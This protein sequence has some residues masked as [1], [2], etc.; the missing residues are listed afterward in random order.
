MY[1]LIFT[2]QVDVVYRWWLWNKQQLRSM[3]KLGL[4]AECHQSCLQ[5]N[6]YNQFSLS[7]IKVVFY[8]YTTH[9]L[10]LFKNWNL[11]KNASGPTLYDDAN[12]QSQLQGTSHTTSVLAK[13]CNEI[14]DAENLNLNDALSCLSTFKKKA[15]RVMASWK[16]GLK[17]TLFSN[18]SISPIFLVLW[19]YPL[20]SNSIFTT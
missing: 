16:G 13:L 20:T 10:K 12:T 2:F 1:R 9:L 11:T 19:F 3:W 5:T 4:W 15:V 7:N 17:L 6:R 18:T 8:L 14:S